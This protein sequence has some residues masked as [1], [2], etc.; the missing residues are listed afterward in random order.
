MTCGRQLINEVRKL[1][2]LS[3]HTPKT[4]AV[5]V[6]GGIDLAVDA[7]AVD[8]MSCSLREIRMRVPG[9]NGAGVDILKKW[10][11]DLCARVTYL[12][13]QLGPL[14][15]DTHGKQVLIR[16]AAPDQ[17]DDAKSFYEVLLQSQ[18]AGVFTLRRYRRDN[19]S[20]SR[21]HVELRTTLELLEKLADDLVATVPTTTH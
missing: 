7:L 8:S 13:E 9:L 21:E 10:A 5:S 2:G 1:S 18:G 17:R 16:S 14:E 12:L 11:N 20:N 3:G 4:A 6:A 19:T 15:I